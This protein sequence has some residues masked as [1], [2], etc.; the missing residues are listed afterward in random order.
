M[1]L[2]IILLYLSMCCN[3]VFNEQIVDVDVILMKSEKVVEVDISANKTN[4]KRYDLYYFDTIPVYLDGVYEDQLILYENEYYQLPIQL[5]NSI[6]K[7]VITQQKLNTVCG[8]ETPYTVKGC[9][10]SE[11]SDM[12]LDAKYRN[13]DLLHESIHL[14]SYQNDRVFSLQ[15][16]QIYA[17]EGHRIA[18]QTGNTHSIYEYFVSAYLLY[19]KQTQY[20]M[21][22][23]PETKL[24]FDHCS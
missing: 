2:K 18:V 1:A 8:V 15:F 21:Q 4:Q 5:K 10:R 6:S 24:Y 22:V 17:I 19:L 11:F 7:I 23:C 3:G 13:G 12:L 14:Y 9:A 16:A 20:L